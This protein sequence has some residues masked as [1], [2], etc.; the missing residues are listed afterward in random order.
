[1]K[2][3]LH[4]LH[5]WP[6][7]A[8]YALAFASIT[9]ALIARWLLD[10]FFG[11]ER[12]FITLFI[13]L[14]P[15]L[16]L[17]RPDAFLVAAL[18]GLL[19]VWY[20]LIPTHFSFRIDASTN[21]L[22]LELFAI[23]CVVA[24]IS[25]WLSHRATKRARR[26]VDQLRE[27]EERF[28]IMADGLPHIVWVHG[29]DGQQQFVNKTFCEFFGVT[30]E[31]MRG[32]RWKLLTHQDDAQSYAAKFIECVRDRKPFN[33]Q[34]RVRR[35]DGAWR[36]IE[37]WGQPRFTDTGEFLGFVGTSIDVTERRASDEKLKRVLESL[38]LAQR[39]GNAG[40]W[41]WA[42]GEDSEAYLS[43]EYR[44]LYGLDPHQPFTY[45]DWLT[46]L[47]PDDRQRVAEYG[48]RVFEEGGEEYLAEFRITHPQRGERWIEGVGRV[49]RDE[50]GRPARF[51][52]INIDITERKRWEQERA[53]HAV[54]LE[55]ALAQ[56]TL[57][58]TESHE[59]LRRTE[60]MAVLGTLSAGIAHDLGNLLLPLR[61]R[62]QTL[63]R[64]DAPADLREDLDAIATSV[65]YIGDLAARLRRSMSDR[66]GQPAPAEP[67]ELARW[68]RDTEQFLRSLL[69]PHLQLHCEIP[70]GLPTISVS[71]VGL[72]QAVYNLVQN[73]AKAINAANTGSAIRL[74]A[75]ACTMNHQDG[76]PIQAVELSVEDDGPGMPPEIRARCLE[77]K[78]STDSQQGSMG[79]GLSLVKAFV[80]GVGGE[81]EVHSPPPNTPRGTQIIMR[82]PVSSHAPQPQIEIITRAATAVEQPA[83]VQTK[84]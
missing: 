31:E 56:R 39:A 61:L 66:E 4:P 23:A 77:P 45:E 10:P 44:D 41:D 42:I 34:V 80:D 57:E 52:G 76:S 64:K 75:G 63:Q 20:F 78:F 71:K 12:Q 81:I 38:A 72:A 11:E 30:R 16:L 7:W 17:V 47:H 29:P 8:H 68:C 27:S 2:R 84:R 15:M 5:T 21:I 83:L 33:A 54:A 18:A 59:R 26:M 73:S 19:G 79:L 74:R 60:A 65:E 62:L 36:W 69:P 32:G 43:P 49:E 3:P 22:D 9:L 13:V 14:L 67:I 53:Q 28:R 24:G 46:H 55:N 40:I 6:A 35:H 1:M 82:F 58:L 48:R 25:A 70:R 51:S 50:N 37:S